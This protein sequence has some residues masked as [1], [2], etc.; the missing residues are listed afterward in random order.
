MFSTVLMLGIPAKV[1]GVKTI[2]LATP[3]SKE[4]SVNPVILYAAKVVGI[5][6]I[7]KV[8]GASAVAA[9]SYGTESVDKVDKIFGPGNR[10]V[11]YAK[12]I[13]SSRT[14]LIC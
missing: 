12:M 7:I 9:L 6:K 14:Q 1:A 10:Y 11:S 8:G 13:V 2:V 3:P 5:D 4:G